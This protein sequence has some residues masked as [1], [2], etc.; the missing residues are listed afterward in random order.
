MMACQSFTRLSIYVYQSYDGHL[1]SAT[2]SFIL[3]VQYIVRIFS[4]DL[5]LGARQSF[6]HFDDLYYVYPS[7]F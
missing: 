3:F 2:Y 6:F 7:F 1:V 5:S 4:C